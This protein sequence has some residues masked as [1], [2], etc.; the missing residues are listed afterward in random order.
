MPFIFIHIPRCGG[1]SVEQALIPLTTLAQS[2]LDLSRAER[3]KHWLEGNR[4]RQ[5][6]KVLDFARYVRVGDYFK[7]AF[8]RNPWARAVS[9]IEFLRA[10]SFRSL[11][12]GRTFK[13]NLRIYCEI[14]EVRHGHDLRAC[15][16]DY[17]QDNNGGL[18][19]D[20]VGRFESLEKDFRHA[21][22]IMGLRPIPVLPHANNSR[23]KRHYSTY[24]DAES[25]EWIRDRFA[26]DIEYFG[27]KFRKES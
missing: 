1:T 16:F 9:Q 17:L 13:D 27:Y 20:F 18:C 8:V 2:G 24:Y 5:H 7:F 12:P 4:G 25:V 21:G 14:K 6:S 10:G 22:R 23:R 26:K 19:V 3:A 15:Q 11:F